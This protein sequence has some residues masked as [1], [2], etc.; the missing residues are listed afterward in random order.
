M[1]KYTSDFP[2]PFWAF[3]FIVKALFSGE[4]WS[5]ETVALYRDMYYM[6]FPELLEQLLAQQQE[7]QQ[8][9]QE[10]QLEE[11]PLEIDEVLE[12]EEEN[13][14]QEEVENIVVD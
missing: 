11:E 1:R 14:E 3:E 8:Q 9:D 6:V 2:Y 7:Q 5:Q 13:E 10:Q 4:P 12:D